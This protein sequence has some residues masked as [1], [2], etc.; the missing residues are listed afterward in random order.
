MPGFLIHTSAKAT[1][2][3]LVAWL[4]TRAMARCSAAARHLVWT[5]ALI[6]ALVLPLVQ[7]VAPRWNVPLLA[8]A[9]MA[10]APVVGA[11]VVLPALRSPSVP[12]D[13][14]REDDLP[15]PAAA[16]DPRP[17]VDPLPASAASSE[18]SWVAAAMAVWIAG[19]TMALARLAAGLAWVSR[20]T[21]E[22]ADV[23]DSG[24]MA[25]LDELTA[26]FSITAPISL[27]ISSDATI[28]VTG[29][30]WSPAILLPPTAAEWPDARRRV[31]LLHELAHVARRDC[32]VRTIAEVV[33]A[34]HW[35]NPLAHVAVARL[36]AEQERAADDLVLAAGTDAPVYADHLFEIARTFRSEPFPQWA[37][38]AMARPSNLEG[39][40]M[41]ILDDRRN[42]Q[43]L[44]RGVRAA[45][46]ASAAA[47]I[48]PIG[49]LQVTA[50][51]RPA[52][53]AAR[54]VIAADEQATTIVT[55]DVVET[56]PATVVAS[57]TTA[58][59][60]ESEAPVTAARQFADAAPDID[61]DVDVVVN[62]PSPVPQPNPEPY[63]H[64]VPWMTEFWSH[65]HMNDA[66]SQSQSRSQSQ[67][68]SQSQ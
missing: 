33:R 19:L 8:A 66:G 58:L 54:P 37:T 34:L 68:Q 52:E 38:V 42:R 50:A 14:P 13:S 30:I 53:P 12:I 65:F 27:K 47:L 48:L 39:R 49:A 63:P 56:A 4:L 41:D 64:L 57:E 26:A 3:L 22:A 32:L 23:E 62:D 17:S 10:P 5:L 7:A 59:A 20:I 60:P 9:P 46:G 25:L 1:V 44:A 2:V 18:I 15:L 16:P 6:A 21:R 45:V 28:P 35:F 55:P 67:S 24:W 29:G 40:V 61:V 11:A 31:V 51:A 36:R 43:P